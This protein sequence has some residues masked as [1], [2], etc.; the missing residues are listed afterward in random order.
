M[1]KQN[2]TNTTVLVVS[3]MRS[4]SARIMSQGMLRTVGN[5]YCYYYYYY[6]YYKNTKLNSM[7]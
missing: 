2:F 1:V 3:Q 6:Y 4:G 5:C 7:V